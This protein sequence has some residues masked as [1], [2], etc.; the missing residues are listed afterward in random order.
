MLVL[1]VQHTTG[2]TTSLHFGGLY[3]LSLGPPSPFAACHSGT[4]GQALIMIES[5]LGG[6]MMLSRGLNIDSSWPDMLNCLHLMALNRFLFHVFAS[7]ESRKWSYGAAHYRVLPH[8]LLARF[9][10]TCTACHHGPLAFQ[11]SPS[12]NDARS[13][14]RICMYDGT[15]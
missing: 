14:H 5:P 11:P 9:A 13:V 15:S 1:W 3:V 6:Y 7:A 4:R 8:Y 2:K 12:L 10:A